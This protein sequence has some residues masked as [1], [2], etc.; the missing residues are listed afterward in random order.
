MPHDT[1]GSTSVRTA[2]FLPLSDLISRTF[3]ITFHFSNF[4]LLWFIF[5][6]P[7]LFSFAKNRNVSKYFNFFNQT[8]KHNIT[9]Q[10]LYILSSVFLIFP[11]VQGQFCLQGNEKASVFPFPCPHESSGHVRAFDALRGAKKSLASTMRLGGVC[12]RHA[13]RRSF[14][15]DQLQKS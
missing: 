15:C 7:N 9:T 14:L 6:F 13:V 2:L 8:K 1:A 3:Y 5:K 12:V 4:F 10:Q 11:P